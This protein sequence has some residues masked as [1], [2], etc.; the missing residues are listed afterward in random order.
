MNKTEFAELLKNSTPDKINTALEHA[1]KS[2]VPDIHIG[3]I[4]LIILGLIAFIS[5]YYLV[6]IK[7]PHKNS[8]NGK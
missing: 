4:Y 6:M 8:Y 1:T 5:L 7:K 3:K 2:I